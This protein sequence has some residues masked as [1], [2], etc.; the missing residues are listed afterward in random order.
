M[1]AHNTLRTA[2]TV[3]LTKLTHPVVVD[4]NECGM[5][6]EWTPRAQWHADSQAIEDFDGVAW[7]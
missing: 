5:L 2:R 3:V 4:F 7:R 1:C 6:M